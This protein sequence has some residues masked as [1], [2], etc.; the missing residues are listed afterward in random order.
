MAPRDRGPDGIEAAG[1]AESH[2]RTHSAPRQLSFGFRDQSC[3]K[4]HVVALTGLGS[5]DQITSR[6]LRLHGPCAWRRLASYLGA[7]GGQKSIRIVYA[8]APAAL[9]C[10]RAGAGLP[11][12]AASR[13]Y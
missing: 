13:P 10:S 12:D 8:V 11:L 6:A 5:A 1:V 7:E 2:C 3:T 4:G 9:I